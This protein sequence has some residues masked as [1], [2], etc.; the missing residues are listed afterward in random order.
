VLIEAV[1]DP[2]QPPLPANITADQVLHFA[3]SVAKGTPDR[4]KILKSILSE[5]VRE[6]V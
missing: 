5:K 3:K 6:L 1:V 4:G 2:Y